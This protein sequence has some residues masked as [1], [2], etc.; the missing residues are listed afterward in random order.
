MQDCVGNRD[1][2]LERHRSE[3]QQRNE[4]KTP[5]IS[6]NWGNN[7]LFCSFSNIP[8]IWLSLLKSAEKGEKDKK[9]HRKSDDEDDECDEDAE[10]E[11]LCQGDTCL[12]QTI[13][14]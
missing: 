9:G 1:G 5:G 2:K 14:F 11:L 12:E 4:C 10:A 3:S 8:T 7:T 6:K 13:L